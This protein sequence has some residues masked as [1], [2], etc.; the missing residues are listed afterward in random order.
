MIIWLLGP[1]VL[2]DLFLVML[3][4]SL[5]PHVYKIIIKRFTFQPYASAL[6]VFAFLKSSMELKHSVE[7]YTLLNRAVFTYL[8]IDGPVNLYLYFHSFNKAF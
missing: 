8:C 2:L 6:L 7:D 1:V 4:C 5:S 3:P